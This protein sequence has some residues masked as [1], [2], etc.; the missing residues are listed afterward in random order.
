MNIDDSE[1]AVPPVV[2]TR[3]SSAPHAGGRGVVRIG[4]KKA[5]ECLDR[6]RTL[7]YAS[8][9]RGNARESRGQMS[10]GGAYFSLAAA[11]ASRLG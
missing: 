3:K 1:V 11:E 4:V 7:R 10:V 9:R 8:I 2:H 5:R 6:H